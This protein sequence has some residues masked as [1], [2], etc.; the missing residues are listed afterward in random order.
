MVRDLL[1]G[2]IADE[3]P[4]RHV[5]MH[6]TEQFAH[7]R[8]ILNR[9]QKKQAHHHFGIKRRPTVVLAVL[10]THSVMHKRQIQHTVELL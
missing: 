1:V 3:Q 10:F 6:V 5:D 2:S 7:R 8:N 9:L 4:V